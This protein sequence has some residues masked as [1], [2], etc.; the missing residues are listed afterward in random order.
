VVLEEKLEKMVGLELEGD[1][2]NNTEEVQSTSAP[3]SRR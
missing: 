2:L 1:L 3:A